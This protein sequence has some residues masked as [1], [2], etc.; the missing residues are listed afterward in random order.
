VS[1]VGPNPVDAEINRRMGIGKPGD[2]LFAGAERA[3][4]RASTRGERADPTPDLSLHAMPSLTKRRT[5]RS[6][7]RGGS[8]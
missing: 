1:T 7:S 4:A 3:A 5:T 2:L 8:R 6:L